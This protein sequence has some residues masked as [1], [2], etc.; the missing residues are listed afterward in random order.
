MSHRSQASSKTSMGT[1]ASVDDPG[2]GEFDE[3]ED[4]VA[5]KAAREKKDG[6]KRIPGKAINDVKARR[7]SSSLLSPHCLLST[8]TASA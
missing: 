5:L 3:D 6:T 7:I 4:S 8:L 1:S 2:K